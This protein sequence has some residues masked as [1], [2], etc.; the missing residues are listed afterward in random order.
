MTLRH[1]KLVAVLAPLVFLAAVDIVR[2]VVAPDLFSAWPGYILLAGI[3]LVG[4]LFF[5][6]TI[7]GIVGRLQDRLAHQNQEQFRK[8]WDEDTNRLDGIIKAIVESD[9]AAEAAKK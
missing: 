8:W 4:A 1:L 3:V 6:D 9:K 5:A 7:F 2:H